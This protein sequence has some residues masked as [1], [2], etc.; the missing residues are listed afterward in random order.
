MNQTWLKYLPAGIHQ[1]LSGQHKL[2]QIIS[3]AGWLVF[4][5]ILRMGF[6]LF[7]GAWVA[8][9]LG[10]TQFGLMNYAFSFVALFSSLATM[11]LDTIV[12]RNIVRDPACS[13]EALGT[14]FVLKLI[15]GFVTCIL[16]FALIVILRPGDSTSHWL[17]AIAGLTTLCQALD[18]ID[19]WFQS[20]VQSKYTVYAKN[21]AFLSVTSV[22][23]VLLFLK[24]PLIAFAW[25]NFA[26]IT[27]GGIM[28]AIAYHMR[29]NSMFLW[30]ASFSQA[31][32]LLRDSWPLILSSIMI[33]IYMRIDQVMLG[34]MSSDKEV[35]IYSAAVRLAE[36]WYFIP[37]AVASSTLPSIVELKA[38]NE[39]RFYE[40]LQKLYCLM[41]FMAYAIA[42]PATFFSE[43]VVKFLFG[44][45]YGKAGMMLVLLIWSGIFTNLGVAR[46]SF[47][48]TMNWTRI[49]FLTVFGGCIINIVLNYLL[50][51]KYGG[52]GAV[53]ASFVAYWFAA[54]GSCLLFRRLHRTAY[55]MTKAMIYPRF[56]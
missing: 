55:M 50:I 39:E 25:A 17:V 33:M 26:E 38:L 29:G 7:V 2:Q 41:A 54:H 27:V 48:T 9:Y 43:W 37:M 30:K 24:A 22:K 5:K 15:G 51:P 49:H 14:T 36:A 20:Q 56:W 4:D 52:M 53:I 47:L 28:L 34:Q 3:N 8:R 35:G 19:F 18:A 16:S 40:K 32:K 23:I 10:P 12:V 13:Y 11:G 21:L 46:S 44:D 31:K 45:A 6:G 42:I 1:R